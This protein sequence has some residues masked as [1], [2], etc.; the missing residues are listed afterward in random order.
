M[1][2]SAIA[3]SR[4]RKAFGDKVVLDIPQLVAELR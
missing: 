1:N 3:A 2:T 4:L